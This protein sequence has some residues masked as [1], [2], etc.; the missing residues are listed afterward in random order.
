MDGTITLAQESRF[1]MMDRQG[2]VHLFTLSP[3]AA[4]EPAQLAPLAAWQ[5]RVRVK[6]RPGDNVLA[7][8]AEAIYVEPGSGV[9]P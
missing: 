8:V 7:A 5:A 6:Y 9:G 4:A 1:Q 3:H 2:A